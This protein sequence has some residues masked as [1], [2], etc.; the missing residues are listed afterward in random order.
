[1][2]VQG[3][4]S[5]NRFRLIVANAVEWCFSSLV[6]DIEKTRADIVQENGI[7]RGR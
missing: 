3:L 4:N 5:S 1:M 7:I 6:E 2:F